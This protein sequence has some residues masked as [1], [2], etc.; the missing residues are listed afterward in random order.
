M[1]GG[2]GKPS[3]VKASRRQ[4]PIPG[5]V[6][7]PKKYFYFLPNM[8]PNILQKEGEPTWLQWVIGRPNE[9]GLAGLIALVHGPSGR[10]RKET[11]IRIKAHRDV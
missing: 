11:P 8:E 6:P 3:M 1:G 5:I 9:G 4:P 2:H 10:A 7:K